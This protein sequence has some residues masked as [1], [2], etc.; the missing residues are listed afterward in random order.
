MLTGKLPYSY[1]DIED[2]DTLKS[3]MCSLNQVILPKEANKLPKG[4]KKALASM[5]QVDPELRPTIEQVLI[6]IRDGPIVEKQ[7]Q[8][9]P[10]QPP[11]FK[12]RLSLPPPPPAF[13]P[14]PTVSASTQIDENTR[15]SLALFMVLPQ[16]IIIVFFKL[17]F[18]DVYKCHSYLSDYS[19]LEESNF[20]FRIYFCGFEIKQTTN[21]FLAGSNVFIVDYCI[22]L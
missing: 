19:V 12:R 2:I 3:V 9:L 10:Q 17:F 21:S 6:L 18:I 7:N 8:Q 13:N 22:L 20:G 15:I 1:A 4:F 5:L 16:G 14:T 11:N